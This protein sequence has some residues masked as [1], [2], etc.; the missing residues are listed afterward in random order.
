MASAAPQDSSVFISHRHEDAELAKAWQQ[1]LRGI[2]LGQIDPW[3]SSD[4]RAGGGMQPGEWFDQLRNLLREAHSILVVVTPGVTEG[5]WVVFESGYAVGSALTTIVVYFYMQERHVPDVFRTQQLYN[6]C[7]PKSVLNL[8]KDV[9]HRH[10]EGRSLPD[11]SI[12]A[13]APLLETY[14]ATVEGEAK[15]TATRAL[16]HDHFHQFDA[17][18]GMKGK[19]FA[20][21]TEI[22]DDGREDVFEVDSLYAWTTRERIR[23]VGTSAKVGIEDLGAAARYYPMEGVVSDARWVALSYWSGGKIP[24][25]GTVL[26]RPRGATGE[27]L[28]GHWQGYTSSDIRRDPSFIRGRVVMARRRDWVEAQWRE[29][30]PD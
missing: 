2:S 3:F 1:L 17:A 15:R 13:W 22:H 25:C 30:A 16:F 26:L 29:P 14:F 9:M 8:C 18:E 21:W 24:I 11:A 4:D 6:G 23:F 5:S 12:A 19:W 28:E 20:K 7:D 10:L 27:L